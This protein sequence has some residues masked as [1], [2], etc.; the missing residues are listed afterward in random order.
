MLASKHLAEE[1]GKGRRHTDSLTHIFKQSDVLCLETNVVDGSAIRCLSSMKGHRK[2]MHGK[3]GEQKQ[4]GCLKVHGYCV[5]RT[6]KQE[7]K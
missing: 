3:R 2:G 1:T 4:S 6:I 7:M 5:W